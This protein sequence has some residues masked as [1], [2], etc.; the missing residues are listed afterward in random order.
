MFTVKGSLKRH[1]PWWRTNIA[2]QYIVGIIAEGYRL[3]LLDIPQHELLK[4]NKSARDNAEFVT[5]ELSKLLESGVIVKLTISP[6]ITNALSVAINADNKK[7]LV[8]D[9]RQINPMLLVSQ[10]KYEDIQVASQYFSPNCF[11]SVFDLKSG[12]HHVDIHRSY[13]QYLAFNWDNTDYVYTTCPFRLASAG[14]IFSKILRELIKRWRTLGI[15]V[16]MYLDYGIIIGKTKQEAIRATQ[17]IKQDLQNSGFIINVEKSNWEPRN[18]VQWLGFILNAETNTFE[19]PEDKLKRFKKNIWHNLKNKNNCGPRELAKTVGK[20]CSLFHVFGSIVYILTKDATHWIANR[21]NWAL[22]VPLNRNVIQEL[23]FWERNLKAAIRMPLVTDMTRDTKIIY[24]DASSTGC[25]A[26]IVGDR[27]TE[28]VHH[29]TEQERKTS[30]T[31]REIK[32]VVLFL[33]LHAHKFRGTS[34]KWYTDN[35]GVPRI[36]HKGSMVQALNKCALEI[37][38]L[39]L[40]NDIHIIRLGAQRTKRRG[41]RTKQNGGHRRLGSKPTHFRLFK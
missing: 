36:V 15:S 22:R 21:Q 9:L 19:A 1:L 17:I 14:L 32:A 7:R 3:P 25:G 10:F 11:L 37:L 4:N 29:W 35:Q 33:E 40:T 27:T 24:S 34:I 31:W 20:M 23:E 12:Y 30:S 16:V 26:F 18:K 28:M 39:C 38:Q 2:N 13:Q 6:T 41:R 8:L 5:S